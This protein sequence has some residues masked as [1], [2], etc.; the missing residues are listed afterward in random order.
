[1]ERAGAT[2]YMALK[3]EAVA[4]FFVQYG[5]AGPF[6]VIIGNCYTVDLNVGAYV[7]GQMR[8]ASV[9]LKKELAVFTK[10]NPLV[11]QGTACQK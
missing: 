3:A 10:V 2:A 5:T 4:N 9:S 11:K 8:L 6:P 7:G 1:M